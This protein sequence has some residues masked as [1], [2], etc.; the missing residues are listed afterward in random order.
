VVISRSKDAK[1]VTVAESRA[2]LDVSEPQAEGGERNLYAPKKTEIGEQVDGT[3]RR[4]G[5]CSDRRERSSTT[6]NSI[7]GR[8]LRA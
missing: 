8:G 4:K 1:K 7:L 2:K 3:P 6:E 5:D